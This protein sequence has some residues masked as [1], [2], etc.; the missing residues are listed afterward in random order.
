MNLNIG[1]N[2]ELFIITYKLIQ[3][4]LNKILIIF[5][6]LSFAI[7]QMASAQSAQIPRV[8]MIGEYE[9][10]YEGLV[11]S[12]EDKLLSVCDNSM[13]Q[14]YNKWMGMLSDMEAYSLK[15]EFDLRGIK[16]WINVFWNQDGTVKNIV[17]YPK[18]NSKNMNFEELTSFFYSFLSDYQ[19]DQKNDDCFSF[20]GSASFPTFA[21]IVPAQEK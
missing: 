21:K 14:A 5:A 8:F 18:P 19:L 15:S 12:C 9:D 13:E 11:V 10:E 2:F 7:G 3:I 1:N 4:N 6:F 17:Y 20:Y 16:I